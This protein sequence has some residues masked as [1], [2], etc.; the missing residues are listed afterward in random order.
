[1]QDRSKFYLRAREALRALDPGLDKNS[2]S[3]LTK[4]AID[5]RYI[6]ADRDGNPFFVR[7]EHRQ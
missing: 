7:E 6:L 2:L 4:A 3:A 5:R 1:M